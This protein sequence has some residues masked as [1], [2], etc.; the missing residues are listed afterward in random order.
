MP[1]LSLARLLDIL[2]ITA[3][4]AYVLL[5]VPLTPFHA[6]EA[7]QIAM[8]RDYFIQF[9][10]SDYDRLR[11]DPA[12]PLTA[13]MQLRLI[14]GTISKTLMGLAW[15]LRGGTADT[16]SGD[17]DWGADWNYNITTG[18]YPSPELLVAARLPSALF[19]A[20]GVPLMFALGWLLGG[21]PAAWA[22]ALL[23]AIHPVLLLNGRR[24]MMEGS[25]IF[26]SLL[27]VCAAVWFARRRSWASALGLGVAGALTLASKHTGAAVVAAV[28][29]GL[30]VWLLVETILL[31]MSEHGRLR[32]GKARLAPTGDL[33]AVG[34]RHASSV[35]RQFIMLVAAALLVPLVFFALNPAWWGGD[36]V[37]IGRTILAWRQELIT[38]QAA[39]HQGYTD[40][41][42]QLLGF[43]QMSFGGDPQYY[44]VTG[45]GE[46]AQMRDQIA[47]YE[48]SPW[49]G[50]RWANAVSAALLILSMVG[51]FALLRD[52]KL[53]LAERLI[54]LLW[55]GVS[56]VITFVSPLAWQR[57]YLPIY[58]PMLL[59]AVYAPF[60]MKRV[61]AMWAAERRERKQVMRQEA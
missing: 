45:W 10:E 16:L 43:A 56:I 40:T 25:L 49:G 48:A 55:A 42:T 35:R 2:L 12:A 54:L 6:D 21:R 24:A 41:T 26:F 28:F 50:L 59:M 8:S 27:T 52:P 19:L 9:V 58:P 44:E 13:E 39:D 53:A 29:V 3:L 36:P 31:W 20:A 4:A 14:N 51:L 33:S 30:G 11:Y 34:T 18:R 46:I 32:A 17:W 57:Y 47:T 22:A 38:A 60:G 23:F 37:Q 5:G 1:R 7:T 15:W 61:W